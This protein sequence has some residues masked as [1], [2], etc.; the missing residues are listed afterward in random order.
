MTQKEQ[1]LQQENENLAKE[2]NK[3]KFWIAGLINKY[4]ESGLVAKFHPK[5]VQPA[6]LINKEDNQG[7]V[8]LTLHY[9]T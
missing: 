5:D 7:N 4:G 6:S 9:N 8:V 1:T 2:V 3:L